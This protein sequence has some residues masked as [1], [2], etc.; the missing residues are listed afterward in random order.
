MVRQCLRWSLQWRVNSHIFV[1]RKKHLVHAL[2][3]EDLQLIGQ[4]SQTHRRRKWFSSH[5]SYW[6]KWMGAKIVVLWRAV[7]KIKAS[8][9][10]FKQAGL[11]SQSTHLRNCKDMQCGFTQVNLQAKHNQTHGNLEVEGVR[12]KSKW[13]FQKQRSWWQCWRMV[14]AF[15]LSTFC[16]GREQ[17]HLLL[18]G[19][20]K[21]AKGL[22]KKKK[23]A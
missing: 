5:N 13:T 9:G 4:T 7:A 12:S 20:R 14:K 1:S 17:H 8:D 18:W 16:R 21:L 2:I 19:M 6:K 22:A 11:P 10:N 3:E 15:H 23:K